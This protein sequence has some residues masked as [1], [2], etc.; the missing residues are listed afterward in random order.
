MVSP[1]L[2]PDEEPLAAVKGVYNA[3]EVI[4]EPLGNVIFYGQGA[5]AGATAS[6]VVGDLMQIMQSGTKTATPVFEKAEAPRAFSE[7]EC[8]NYVAT[9]SAKEAVT[10]VFGNAKFV[11]NDSGEVI[12]IT[13]KMS[14]SDF[15][16]KIASINMNIKS[17]IRML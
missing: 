2:I 3:I 6:A 14:E 9:D 10:Q 7:F 12:F 13:E 11:P 8:R 16:A 4:G 15:E 5:G 17:R 1:F